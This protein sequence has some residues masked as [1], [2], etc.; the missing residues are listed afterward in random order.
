[1]Y[2]DVTE[3]RNF[4]YRSRLGRSVQRRLQDEIKMMWP[5]F[6]AETMVGFGFASPFLR[7]MRGKSDNIVNL[8]PE[9]QGVM[10]WPPGERNISAL[11]SESSWP[12]GAGMAD[13]MLVAHA[14]E[15]SEDIN[16]LMQELWR[17]MAPE[18]RAILIVSN[19]MG[20]WATSDA[21][22][23]GFGRPYSFG[24]VER[25]LHANRFEVTAHSGALFAP[26]MTSKFG[27]KSIG[28]L[29]W[30]FGGKSRKLFAGALV[31]E[32]RKRVG[33]MPPKIRAQ[34]PIFANPVMVAQSH[35]REKLNKSR[36][37][38]I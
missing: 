38:H 28:F 21:T 22:P 15:C 9:G 30:A 24:Q 35:G 7:P 19:R 31:I 2:H 29:E 6:E 20:V 37:L 17:V 12:L 18:G 26:P 14:I 36:R 11:C 16:G 34:E 23:F 4:Y 3:L 27:L 33:I 13:R 10:A 8:M 32:V 25:M 1:M 5:D